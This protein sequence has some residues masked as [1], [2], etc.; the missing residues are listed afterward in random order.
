[1]PDV[2]VVEDDRVVLAA[3]VRACRSEG[4]EIAEADSVGRALTAMEGT[5]CRLAL[6]DLMLP[7]RDGLELLEIL[8]TDRPAMPV[9]TIS[10]YATAEN[11]VQSLQLG[12]FDFL[13]KPFDLEELVGV[14]RRGL[15]YGGGGRQRSEAPEP[16]EERYFLGRHSW[17]VLDAEGTATVGAAETF[18][19]V[20][21]EVSEVVLPAAGNH[22][23]QGM[24]LARVCGPEETHRVWSP[25]SGLVVA[26]NEGL[27]DAADRLDRFSFDAGWLARIVPTDSEKEL[28]E[29]TYRPV[30]GG[31]MEGG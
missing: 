15:R 10:G 14:V 29:L 17:A 13:P 26:V 8:A 6:V 12:A 25:L 20:L 31:E 11:A 30:G 3:M 24:K 18:H 21:G 27:V 5:T 7:G 19:G 23:T 28:K 1:M 22:A 4:L 16:A 9:V 2:L